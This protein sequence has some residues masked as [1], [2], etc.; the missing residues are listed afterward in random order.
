MGFASNL[1]RATFL[2]FKFPQDSVC[3]RWFVNTKLSN[4]WQECSAITNICLGPA[5]EGERGGGGGVPSLQDYIRVEWSA[6]SKHFTCCHESIRQV[7]MLLAE[8]HQRWSHIINLKSSLRWKDSLAGYVGYCSGGTLTNHV[9]DN[10]YSVILFD[11]IEKAHVRIYDAL[12]QVLDAGRLTDGKVVSS[13]LM[14]VNFSGTISSWWWPLCSMS[15][16]IDGI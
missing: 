3:K 2:V 14:P 5:P 6:T 11:E 7:C 15:S 8:G 12:L 10:P 4:Q 9:S 16:I 1:W 13:N